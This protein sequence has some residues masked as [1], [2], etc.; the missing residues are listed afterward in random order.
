MK[1][2][3]LLHTPIGTLGILCENGALKELTLFHDGEEER[4]F[5]A[6]VEVYGHST[7][8]LMELVK[9]EILEYFNGERTS[10]TI[11]LAPVG[12]DFQ[13]RVWQVLLQIPY[14]KT[15]SY[16]DV[17]CAIGNEKASRAV[18]MAN[19]KNPI[20]IIIPCHR[21]VQSDGFLGGYSGG[22]PIKIALLERE[23]VMIKDDT[24]Q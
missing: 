3:G 15:C 24:I 17:A 18:G 9:K 6:L 22:L 13:Q 5:V 4:H 16:K 12:T 1:E 21:V 19:G 2:Y 8:P 20:I 7:S 14:G 23:G 10:F 11:P